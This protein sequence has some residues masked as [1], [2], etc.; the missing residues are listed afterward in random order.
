MTSSKNVIKLT[1]QDFSI[2]GPSQS[3]FVCTQYEIF[4]LTET[5]FLNEKITLFFN[6]LQFC[7][8]Y[9]AKLIT[10]YG[11]EKHGLKELII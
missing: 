11:F 1:S 9:T 3:K 6:N 10:I 2:L 5:R 7:I 4:N 8:T